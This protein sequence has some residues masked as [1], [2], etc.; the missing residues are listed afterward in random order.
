MSWTN[1]PPAVDQLR[2]DLLAC[3]TF[4]AVFASNQIHYPAAVLNPDA[5]SADT[6]P[7]CVLSE[8]SSTP[9]PVASGGVVIPGGSLTVTLHV[10]TD[11]GDLEKL[12][13][14]T[15]KELMGLVASLPY[16]GG[17]TALCSDPTGAQLAQ[18]NNSDTTNFRSIEINLTWGLTP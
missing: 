4:A 3:T 1:P 14:A 12:A 17:S 18:A 6:L 10:A 16:R 11:A 8:D 7:I 15:I 9:T 2:T 5:G 13:R